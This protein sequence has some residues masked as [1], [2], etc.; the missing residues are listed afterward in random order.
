MMRRQ[1][2]QEQEQHQYSCDDG[3]HSLCKQ[4]SPMIQVDVLPELSE[5]ATCSLHGRAK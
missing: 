5:P 1:P 4:G 3:P 2:V